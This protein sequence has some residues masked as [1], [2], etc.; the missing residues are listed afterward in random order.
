MDIGVKVIGFEVIERLQYGD[1]KT[2]R[3]QN[4]QEIIDF[5]LV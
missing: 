3:L 5:P 1:G 4:A 2:D